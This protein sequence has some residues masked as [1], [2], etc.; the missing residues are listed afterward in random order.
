LKNKAARLP[1][2]GGRKVVPVLW[3]AAVPKD[4]QKSRV[5]TPQQVLDALR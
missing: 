4:M 2:V 5:V 1:F 3:L